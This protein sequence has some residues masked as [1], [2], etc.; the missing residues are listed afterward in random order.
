MPEKFYP[1]EEE[2]AKFTADIRKKATPSVERA[3][4]GTQEIPNE[5]KNLTDEEIDKSVE[6]LEKA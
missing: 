4:K 2:I 5:L 1:R 3:T 6:G